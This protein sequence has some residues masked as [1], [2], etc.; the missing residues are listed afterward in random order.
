MSKKNLVIGHRGWPTRY[1]DNTLAGL[2]AAAEVADGVEVDIRRSKDGKLVLS[3]DPV[4]CGLVVSETEWSELMELDLGGGHHPILLDEAL[5]ALPNTMV[6]L[7]VK[8][9]FVDPGFEPDHRI[10]LEVAS[11]ARPQDAVIGFNWES[12]TVVRNRF[13]DVRTGVSSELPLT[14]SSVVDAARTYGHQAAIVEDGQVLAG[15]P[16]DIDV[17]VWTVNDPI[18][19]TELAQLGATGIITDDPPAVVEALNT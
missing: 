12:I 3:H 19:A 8:N 4:L 9:S 5:A 18:R 17:F 6:Q 16:R 7:E 13:P 14:L 10:A 11:R 15:L 1:P 2:I